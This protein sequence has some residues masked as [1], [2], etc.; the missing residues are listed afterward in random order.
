MTSLK[1]T[2]LFTED[3]ST[4][5]QEDSLVNHTHN[6]ESDLGK[7]MSDTS[8][9]RCLEQYKKFNHD[10]LLAKMFS[11][12][13][14]GTGDWYSK[15]CKLTWRLKG[16]KYKRMYFQLVPKT[17]HTEEIESGLWLLK[18]PTMMDG[19]V[20]SG[21]KNP[22][23]GNSGTLAQEIMSSYQP[24]MIKLGMLP[25][26]TAMDSTNATVNM[27]SLQLTEG[28][29]HSVTLTRAMAMGM[30]PTPLASEE[31]KMSG[32]ETENQMSI[33]KLV[34]RDYGKNSQLSPQFVAEM[35]G[36]P[37]HWTELPFLNGEKNQLKHTETQ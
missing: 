34:K 32:S 25:T 29:M 15:K 14:I 1:Q 21:K 31:G 5:S 28:S 7:K 24:T 18:T 19:M 6:L 11:D 30:L 13:L 22:I 23:S 26:P 10:G 20:T 16:T 3:K 4:Y 27:K 8:G 33:T 9:Q 35:M 12:L 17:H 2:S 36:F 37:E